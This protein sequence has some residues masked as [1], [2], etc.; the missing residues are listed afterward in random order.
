MFILFTDV[1]AD[2]HCH[3]QLYGQLIPSPLSDYE[4]NRLE[5]EMEKPTGVQT[6]SKPPLS[7]DAVLLS[8]NCGLIYQAT[9]LKGT[10]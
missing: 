2:T 6:P 10:K 1:P 7:M 4:M 9:H 5:S 3:F 8:K